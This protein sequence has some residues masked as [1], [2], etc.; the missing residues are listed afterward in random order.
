MVQRLV[1]KEGHVKFVGCQRSAD[2]LRQVRVSLDWRQ[3]TGT[4]AFVRYGIGL[5]N[6]ES[7]MGVVVEEERSD[8]VVVDKEQDIRLPVRQPFTHRLVG[9]KNRS[10]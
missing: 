3:C 7:E 5:T 8:V 2:M 6:A 4:A 1:L 10:P 9:L